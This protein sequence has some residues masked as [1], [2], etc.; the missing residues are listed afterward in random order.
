MR[1]PRR[2][3]YTCPVLAG[4]TACVVLTEPLGAQSGA[5]AAGVAPQ[6]DRDPKVAA[7]LG[8]I[9]PG[10]GHLY[11]GEYLHG[12]LYYEGTVA[13]IGA[14]Y[15]VTIWPDC[16]PFSADPC[17]SRPAWPRQLFGAAMIATGIGVWV[18][19]AIDAPRAVRR[20]EVARGVVSSGDR[21]GL[22]WAPVVGMAS[23]GPT[24]MLVGFQGRW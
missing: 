16:P 8:S 18:W 4:L 11:A 12:V 14:G 5:L 10:S 24:R 7:V 9:V 6:P 13:P 1:T 23:A 2:C 19:S 17:D 15:L 3:W 21:R 20:R 22:R